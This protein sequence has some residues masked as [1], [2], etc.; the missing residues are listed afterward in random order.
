MVTINYSDGVDTEQHIADLLDATVDLAS[1]TDIFPEEH[2]YWP[3]RYH[4]SSVRSNAI[5]HLNFKGLDVLELGAGMGACSRFIAENAVHLTAVEGTESRMNCLRK[6]LRDLNNWDGVVSNYQDFHT[7]K[8]Y[9]VVCFFGVLEYAGRYIDSDNPFEWAIKH[10]KSFLKEDGVM[11]ITIENKNGLKYFSGLA[12]DHFLKP[13]WGICGYPRVHDVQTF[14]RKE[15]VDML[16]KSGLL[17]TDVH[18]LAPDYKCTRA[19]V[20]DEFMKD[21]P[22]VAANIMS[23]HC[24]ENYLCCGGENFPSKLASVSLAKSGLLGEF[25]NSYLF[26]S[27]SEKNSNVKK[28]LLRTVAEEKTKAFSYTHGKKRN[29]LTKFVKKSGEYV[30]YKEWVASAPKNLDKSCLIKNVLIDTTPLYDGTELKYLMLKHAYYGDGN[31]MLS[32][33]YDYLDYVFDKYKTDNPNILK[34]EAFDAIPRNVIIKNGEYKFFD[35]EYEILFDLTKDY[36]LFRV[37]FDLKDCC[38]SLKNLGFNSSQDFY[39]HLCSKFNVVADIR[40]NAKFE[41]SVQSELGIRFCRDID[42][43]GVLNLNLLVNSENLRISEQDK[44]AYHYDTSYLNKENCSQYQKDFDSLFST[45]TL[46]VISVPQGVILPIKG[47]PKFNCKG[48]VLSKNKEYQKLSGWYR[49]CSVLSTMETGYDCDAVHFVDQ[50]VIYCG[51]YIHQWGH[52]LLESTSRLWYWLSL[53]LEER[54]RYKLAFLCL[55]QQKPHGNMLEF[56]KLLGIKEDDI[57]S[58]LTPTQFRSV[59]IPEQSSFLGKMYTKEFLIPF[60]EIVKKCSPT[61]ES[62][63][64]LSRR[65]FK[66]NS[67]TIVEE[68]IEGFFAKNGFKVIYPETL[69]LAEQISLMQG[70]KEVAMLN[71]S[72]AHN[73]LFCKP[74]TKV[75]IVNR[76]GIQVE[77]Q[78][79][80]DHAKQ[81]RTTYIDGYQTFLPALHGKGPFLMSVTENLIRFAKDHNMKLKCRPGCSQEEVNTYLKMWCKTYSEQGYFDLLKSVPVLFNA[82][83]DAF[84]NFF[85]TQNLRKKSSFWYRINPFRKCQY[86]DF[87]DISQYSDIQVIKKSRLFNKFWYL[88]HYYADIFKSKLSAEEHYLTVGF[89]EGKNPSWKFDNDFYLNIYPDIK[90]CGMNPLIHYERFGRTEGRCKQRVGN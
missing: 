63:I 84:A 70:A 38:L 71:G 13:Y 78:F 77:P 67:N 88:R 3:I 24:A 15:M 39:E 36:F 56:L 26:I 53:P 8:K 55:Y 29:V 58:V 57:I 50:D 4:L 16:A 30:V 59:I 61:A 14:S 18:H 54:S 72:A 46:Q 25:S 79:V 74:Q 12:E 80:C 47:D 44:N 11:L 62:K 81:L 51:V 49:G 2:H 19:V 31:K 89:K 7:T 21:N 9:D 69:P 76:F 20:T 28:S 22:I 41:A 60:Q 10:A 40:K 32:L 6:R 48:G 82:M 17:F 34:K 5:R 73:T 68:K 37:V 85:K 42:I 43:F 1:T 45:D 23:N 65:R 86:L 66:E 27:S 87:S 90:K 33:V 83:P 52:F 64:Y 35:I 75:I